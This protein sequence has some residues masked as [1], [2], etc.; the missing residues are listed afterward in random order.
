MRALSNQWVKLKKPFV[1]E[2]CRKQSPVLAQKLLALPKELV[3]KGTFQAKPLDLCGFCGT[4]E[5]VP[6]QNPIYATNF[7][8]CLNSMNVFR[9]IALLSPARSS[10]LIS[11]Q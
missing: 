8:E 1:S 11:R 3:K 4:T 10:L 9:F 2:A 7:Y 6:F 5:V